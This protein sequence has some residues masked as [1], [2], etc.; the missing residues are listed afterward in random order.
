MRQ[1]NKIMDLFFS[2]WHHGLGIYKASYIII[3]L[4]RKKKP[5]EEKV[6]PMLS[7]IIKA[8]MTVVAVSIKMSGRVKQTY[9]RHREINS[10]RQK[11]RNNKTNNVRHFDVASYQSNHESFIAL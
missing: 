2:Y 3:S 7:H 6:T 1:K 4:L 10:L 8:K 5:S 9:L 11:R